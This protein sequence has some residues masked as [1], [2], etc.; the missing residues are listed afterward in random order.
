[1]L[2]AGT[3]LHFSPQT[4]LMTTWDYLVPLHLAQNK[5][6][7]LYFHYQKYMSLA[8]F[9]LSVFNYIHLSMQMIHIYHWAPVFA[10]QCKQPRKITILDNNIRFNSANQKFIAKSGL[11]EQTVLQNKVGFLKFHPW[12]TNIVTWK[13]VMKHFYPLFP[14]LHFQLVITLINLALK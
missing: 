3:H 7:L 8:T 13:C 2:Q 4:D 6:P 1:M 14:Q 9:I 11:Y 10:L 5:I 12:K